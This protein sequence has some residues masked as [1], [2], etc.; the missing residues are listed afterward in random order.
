VKRAVAVVTALVGASLI[1]MADAAVA[2][3]P[4]AD[5]PDDVYTGINETLNFTGT[6]A[7]SLEDRHITITADPGDEACDL[8]E[9]DDGSA[10]TDC[11]FVQIEADDGEAQVSLSGTELMGGTNPGQIFNL[12][13]TTAQIQAA[14]D[15]LQFIPDTDYESTMADPAEVR[16]NVQD[17]NQLSSGLIST[18]VW[19]EGDNDAPDLTVPADAAGN[20]GDTFFFSDT[21]LGSVTVEDDD[22]DQDDL[23]DFMGAVFWVDGGGEFFFYDSPFCSGTLDEILSDTCTGLGFDLPDDAIPGVP[24]G[25]VFGT[26]YTDPA[27]AHALLFRYTEG[28][29]PTVDAFSRLEYIAPMVNCTCTINVIVGDLGN[30]GMPL[31]GEIPDFAFDLDSWDIEVTGGA[32]TTS[33]STTI[34]GSS[35]TSDG[36]STTTDGSTTT[37]DG[38]TTTTDGSTT[39]TDGSTTTTDGST[40]TTDGST[41]TT[42]GST[43]T[44]DGSTTTTDGSTTTTDGSTT[45]T[46][47]STTTTDGSTTTTDGSTTT[48]NGGSTT[49]VTGPTTTGTGPTTTG[50]GT[51]STS[52]DPGTSTTSSSVPEGGGGLDTTTTDPGAVL[53]TGQQQGGGNLPATGSNDL[54]AFHLATWLLAAGLLLQAVSRRRPL[55]DQ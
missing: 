20:V 10:S 2:A 46:D 31:P 24:S 16:I 21:D 29:D 48:T 15:T 52:G 47:G 28:A 55:A 6:D 4:N 3:D 42:D 34:D 45:T 44:T 50:E 26:D 49:S 43:T 14:I 37:T 27:E 11:T 19:V 30:N 32:T 25:L 8:G 5:M 33:S 22:M 53:G 40:T 35:T 36:S 41:T 7:I 13:G 17:G 38:S 9:P 51:T 23:D 54:L 1:L 12:G 39:T 18:T